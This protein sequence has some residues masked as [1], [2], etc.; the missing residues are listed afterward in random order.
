MGKQKGKAVKRNNAFD[1]S[2]TPDKLNAPHSFVIHRGLPFAN[3]TH[4]TKDFRRI[5]EPFTASSLKE[6]RKNK[7][8]DFIS[9][10]GVF[11]VSHMCIFNRSTNQLSF[12][13]ARLPKGPTLNFKIHQFTLSRDVMGS[14]KKQYFNESSFKRSPLVIKRYTNSQS[15]KQIHPTEVINCCCFLGDF[16]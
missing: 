3:I 6:R 13:V 4:L 15:F 11:H 5:M 2:E 10:S 12:K 16:E 1:D 14:M 7:L 9:L 8:K